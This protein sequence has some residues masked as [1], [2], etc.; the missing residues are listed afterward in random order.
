MEDYFA[1]VPEPRAE[2][3]GMV[4]SGN[5]V[6]VREVAYWLTVEGEV[7]QASLAIY[8]VRDGL[9]YRVWYYPVEPF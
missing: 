4:V 7:A 8:E 9:I 5:F 2:I 3:D 6:S 1:S